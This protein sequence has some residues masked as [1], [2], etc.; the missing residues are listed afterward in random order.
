MMV[1]LAQGEG[2]LM[3]CSQSISLNLEKMSLGSRNKLDK[4]S[5]VMIDCR[6]NCKTYNY[7]ISICRKNS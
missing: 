2:A 1:L 7:K 5:G 3:L 6:M 4:L